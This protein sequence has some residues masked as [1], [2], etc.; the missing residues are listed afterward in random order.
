MR[1]MRRKTKN[2]GQNFPKSG[3]KVNLSRQLVKSF[4]LCKIIEKVISSEEKRNIDTF[5]TFTKRLANF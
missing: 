2:S 5:T 4:K 3:Q 1:V